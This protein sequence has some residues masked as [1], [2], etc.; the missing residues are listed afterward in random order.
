MKPQHPEIDASQIHQGSNVARMIDATRICINACR[1]LD[2]ESLAN[3]VANLTTAHGEEIV[4]LLSPAHLAAFDSMIRM[5]ILG[6][7]SCQLNDEQMAEY[8][9]QSFEF[10]LN[11]EPPEAT[12]YTNCNYGKKKSKDGG[13]P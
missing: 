2:A 11:I 7:R 8:S 12:I 6:S 13:E 4:K 3:V 10:A 9:K 5:F 1:G